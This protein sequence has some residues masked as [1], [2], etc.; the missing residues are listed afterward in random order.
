LQPPR[1][2]AGRGGGT[3]PTKNFGFFQNEFGLI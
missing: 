2:L 1:R 3:G